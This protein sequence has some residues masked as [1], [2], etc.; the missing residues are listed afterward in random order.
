[1]TE[2]HLLAVCGVLFRKPF[3]VPPLGNPVQISGSL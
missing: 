1:M 2:R 3:R